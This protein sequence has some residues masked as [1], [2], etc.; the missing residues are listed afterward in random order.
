MYYPGINSLLL[1]LLCFAP[2]GLA[3]GR[4]SES[5][6][7]PNAILLSRVQSLTLRANRLTSSRRV[8][9]IP[10]LKCV[11]PSKTICDKYKIETMRCTNAGYDYDEEDVQWTCTAPLPEEFMLGATDVICEGYR[12]ADDKWVLKGSC[13]V[14][15]RLLL[16][17]RGERRFGKIQ[18]DDMRSIPRATKGWRRGV[19]ALVDL[20][21]LGFWAAVVEEGPMLDEVGADFGEEEVVAEEEMTMGLILGHLLHTA[22]FQRVVRVHRSQGGDRAFGPVL[23]LVAWLATRWVGEAIGIT[24][25]R[26]LLEDGMTTSLG[27]KAAHGRVP[28]LGFRLPQRV[29]DSAQQDEDNA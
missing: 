26:H 12:N 10:Q 16:T 19:D 27:E 9:P 14:E 13:G 29:R 3:Y 18:E 24:T 6:P 22:A 21:F 11:G 17:E 2:P 8:S 1:W 7:G 15:Y 23:R 5:P 4:S 28:L 25:D 20:I